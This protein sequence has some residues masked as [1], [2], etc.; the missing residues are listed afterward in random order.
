MV[1]RSVDGDEEALVRAV[2]N[3]GR[4]P[5]RSP[6]NRWRDRSP[7]ARG[8]RG[9]RC[10]C[11]SRR[12]RWGSARSPSPPRDGCRRRPAPRWPRRPPPPSRGPPGGCPPPCRSPE[13]RD[14][15]RGAN[16]SPAGV[17]GRARSRGPR[18]RGCR[19]ARASRAPPTPHRP[20]RQ[21]S[22]RSTMFARSV[23]WRLAALAIDAPDVPC[24]K[25]I[26]DQTD[27]H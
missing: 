26:R 9:R 4:G 22:I 25:R 11:R 27:P 3:V 14:G 18:G 12:R 7:S 15:A 10:W 8:D 19:P 24:G 2:G 20:P 13:I 16:R 21:A 17:A 23:T 5:A 1:L 6:P